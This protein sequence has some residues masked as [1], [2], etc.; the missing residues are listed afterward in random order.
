MSISS[1]SSYLTMIEQVNIDD[2]YI[3][4]MFDFYHQHYLQ[5]TLA[6]EFVQHSE[7]VPFQMQKTPLIGFVDRTLGTY[8]SERSSYECGAIRGSLQRCGLIKATGH[9]L[10][11]GCVVFPDF[12][13]NHHVISVTGYR[14]AKRIR[15]WEVAVIHWEKPLP[16]EFI[17]KAMITI[18]GLIY[19]KA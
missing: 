19:G 12:N 9:E 17:E 3:Q 14:I 2:I 18:K 6:Q 1:D 8:I 4:E 13:E 7:R 16:G 11:R 10:F 5:S 15:H